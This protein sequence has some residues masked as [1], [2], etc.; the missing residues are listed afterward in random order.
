MNGVSKFGTAGR[1]TTTVAMLALGW[2]AA[3][4]AQSPRGPGYR[5]ID[6][7]SDRHATRQYVFGARTHTVALVDE[8]AQQ[9][10][11]ICWE[12]HNRYQQQRG[13]RETY[14]EMYKVFQDARH[15]QGLVRQN[16]H[17]ER[18][19]QDDHIARDLDEMESLFLH[20]AGD[21]R[22]WFS[23]RRGH[24]GHP[25]QEA[26]PVLMREFERSLQHLMND[27]GVRS[28]LQRAEGPPPAPAPG[29]GPARRE[30]PG[31]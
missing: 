1:V 19:N 2:C 31:R 25:H 9:A 24:P 23:D 6:R 10:N 5:P 26:L 29:Y 21:V 3:A 12:M 30:F 8:L 4:D 13:F 28:R 20:V 27:Y 14:A 15:L 7:P 11:Q 17:R 18:H 22:H 16:Y